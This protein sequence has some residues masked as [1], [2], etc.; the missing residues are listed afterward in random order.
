MR[1][2]RLLLFAALLFGI[3]TMHTAGHPA[4][5]A[6]QGDSAAQG[7]GT[8]HATAHATGRA[9][10]QAARA[11]DAAHG[12]G[13]RPA[14]AEAYP[15]TKVVQHALDGAAFSRPAI[16]AAHQAATVGRPALEGPAAGQPA[17]A[18]AH[19]AAAAA[20]QAPAAAQQAL[21]GPAA[22]R[23]AVGEAGEGHA[24]HGKSR[25]TGMDPSAVCL[26][27]LAGLAAWGV[28]LIAIR[29]AARDEGDGLLTAARARLPDALRPNPP[30]PRTLL[31]QLSV[32]RI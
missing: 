32:L 28:A 10:G 24:A 5:G 29:P 31:T 12:A 4:M 11:A 7:A 1:V 19:P 8:V 9:T 26:A 22:A 14:S 2:R 3:T 17:A 18:P 20:Q 30:P 13:A 6:A 25:G 15:A 27:V 16:A 23:T 21:E